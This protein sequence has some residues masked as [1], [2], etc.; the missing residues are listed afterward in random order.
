[1]SECQ[2]CRIPL[3]PFEKCASPSCP[4]FGTR[5]GSP[6]AESAARA[7]HSRPSVAAARTLSGAAA[8]DHL[9]MRARLDYLAA[10]GDLL[11]VAIEHR[12][13]P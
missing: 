5:P 12:A 13:A 1:M 11:D 10:V 6:E 9:E 3:G 2:V 4:C 7:W 8:L